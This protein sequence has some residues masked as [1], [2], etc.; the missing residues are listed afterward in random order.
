MGLLRRLFS[1]GPR[2]IKASSP[3][4]LLDFLQAER[5][6]AEER[7]LHKKHQLCPH[8]GSDYLRLAAWAQRGLAGWAV[9]CVNCGQVLEET[10]EIEAL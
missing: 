2:K 3:A 8:C 10:T 6:E 5:D 4:Q 9:T 7:L 1:R